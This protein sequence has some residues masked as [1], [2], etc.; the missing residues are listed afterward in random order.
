MSHLPG[1]YNVNIYRRSGD[2]YR[3]DFYRNYCESFVTGITGA[4]G[5]TGATGATGFFTGATGETGNTGFT[6]ATGYTGETGH[7]G[8]TGY[9][10][11]TGFTG[12]T[13]E[14][15]H[16][17]TTGYTGNTGFTGTTGY[18]GHTGATGYTGATG[19]LGS[20]GPTGSNGF[21]S[22]ADFYALMP[23]DN[24]ATIATGADIQ[25]PNDGPIFGTDI[26]RISPATFNLASVST[27]QVFFQASID[28]PAQL[29]IA[30]NSIEIPY[31]IVGR[32]TGT[33]Q[34]AGTSLITTTTPNSVLSI[35]NPAGETAA[36]TL[37]PTAGG[38]KPSSAHL[39][40]TKLSA[41]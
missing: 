16:T 6:G 34:V 41:F 5:F 8:T 20:T 30:I 1:F 37:T 4:T 32:A 7:T 22:F 28:E 25:F 33:T 40:I 3:D 13:G 31:T 29:C 23:P 21:F 19:N 2:Y 18:T 24:A 26:S 10:G 14:T 15:G 27:Y 36:L 17:G 38:I 35:R 39:I 12:T 9:T 11:N